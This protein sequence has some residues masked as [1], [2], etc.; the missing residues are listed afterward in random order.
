[1]VQA[2]KLAGE[3]HGIR[4][5]HVWANWAE[6]CRGRSGRR[7]GRAAPRWNATSGR[8]ADRP[9]SGEIVGSTAMVATRDPEV[10]L[11]H[12]CGGARSR[13]R[14]AVQRHGRGRSTGSTGDGPRALFG[15]PLHG[16]G[17]MALGA[18]CAALEMN[19]VARPLASSIFFVFG[20]AFTRAEI[21]G[22]TSLCIGTVA[23]GWK[24]SAGEAVHCA[25]A[26]AGCA[27]GQHVAISERHLLA[28]ARG[29]V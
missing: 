27:V 12:S 14:D 15:A 20:S 13:R 7:R 24:R 10:A 4:T 9:V 26:A 29:G 22:C 6:P 2:A 5:D 17:S 25:T 11:A 8:N 16:R 23:D 19:V 18:C 3:V 1:M 21:R 28:S